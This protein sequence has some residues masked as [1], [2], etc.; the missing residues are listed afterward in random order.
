M[1]SQEEVLRELRGIREEV[2]RLREEIKDWRLERGIKREGKEKQESVE[3]IEKRRRGLEEEEGKREEEEDEAEG[4]GC[5]NRI[6]VN[7]NAVKSEREEAS[8]EEEIEVQEVEKERNSGG[9]EEKEKNG[10]ETI[11]EAKEKWRRRSEGDVDELEGEKEWRRRMEAEGT[12]RRK[13][14]WE[15]IWEERLE[16]IRKERRKR[17]LIWKGV[18]GKNLEERLKYIKKILEKELGQEVVIK[19]A[20]ERVGEGRRNIVLTELEDEDRKKEMVWTKN[21]IWDRW[22]V[23]VDE[24]LSKEERRM[25]WRIKEKAREEIRKGNWVEFNNRRIWIEGEEWKW[26]ERA[27][28]MGSQQ[29]EGQEI[30]KK[31]RRQG[32]R[33]E[34]SRKEEE[35]AKEK[36][37]KSKEVWEGEKSAGGKGQ[38]R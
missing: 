14:E 33:T 20:T 2:R 36:D 12:M 32:K 5:E 22:R 9:E 3:E 35:K 27:E 26:N 6:E 8:K 11:E 4:G 29:T 30:K 34:G 31:D 21:G 10:R 1:E 13:E 25:K 24:D 16:E 15:K 28:K 38:G 7:E 23:A 18:E 37:Q 17:S 19:R